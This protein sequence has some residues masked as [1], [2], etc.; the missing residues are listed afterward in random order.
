MQVYTKAPKA[1]LLEFLAEAYDIENLA[2][3]DQPALAS[4]YCERLAGQA[5]VTMRP[6]PAPALQTKW[7]AASGSALDAGGNDAEI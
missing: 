5:S 6:P 7:R 2:L 1:K 4:V 3:L